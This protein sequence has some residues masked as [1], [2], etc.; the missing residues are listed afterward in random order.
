LQSS[1]IRLQH[2]QDQLQELHDQIALHNL[3]QPTLTNS[4]VIST[5]LQTLIA[6]NTRGILRD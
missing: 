4:G 5:R 1:L 2:T 3:G 6:E